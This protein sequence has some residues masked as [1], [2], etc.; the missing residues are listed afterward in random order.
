MTVIFL[1]P[2]SRYSITCQ[3]KNGYLHFRK[4]VLCRWLHIPVKNQGR[5]SEKKKVPLCQPQ[6]FFFLSYKCLSFL[7]LQDL[8]LNYSHVRKTRGDGNCFYRAFGF[9]YM[10]LLIGNQAEYDRWNLLFNQLCCCCCF[11]LFVFF[12]MLWAL[13]Q[14]CYVIW[15]K[16]I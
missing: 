2:D 11:C 13:L 8:A 12:Q 15:P 7:I 16:Q 5:I 4:G 10:E 14:K 3:W 6:F 1:I 9:A